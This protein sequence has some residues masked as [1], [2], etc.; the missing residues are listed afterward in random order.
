MV[1]L[2]LIGL[3]SWLVLT[4]LLSL[5]SLILFTAQPTIYRWD[6]SANG[7][8]SIYSTYLWLQTHFDPFRLKKINGRT[9]GV[10]RPVAFFNYSM[11][12]GTFS[13]YDNSPPRLKAEVYDANGVFGHS[14]SISKLE[15][16]TVA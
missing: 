6:Q 12:V 15:Q 11:T 3:Q 7:L 14:S 4:I 5:R 1:F 16:L 13:A 10:L 9:N 8:F 2:V